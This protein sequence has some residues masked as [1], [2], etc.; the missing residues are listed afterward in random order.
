M[1]LFQEAAQLNNRGVVALI[2]GDDKFAIEA[3]TK[4]IKMIKQELA[5]PSAGLTDFKA[6]SSEEGP[7]LRT[8][9]IPDMASSD[10]QHEVFNH[11][12][13]IPYNGDESELDFHVYSAAVIFNLALAHHRMGINGD[14]ACHEKSLKLYKMVLKV[15]D[16]T[17]ISFRTAVTV[18]LATINNLAQIQYAQGDF[19]DA[20]E[21]LSHLAGFLRIANGDVLAEPQVQGL[22]MNVLMLRAPK[23]APA[24]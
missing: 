1:S 20:R 7:E 11:A 18:K 8:V 22:L 2:E 3:M 12:I 23:V 9:E 19:D 21:G 13:H 16:D 17:L 14:K 24:A 4:S 5:K 6:S 15:L 10:E